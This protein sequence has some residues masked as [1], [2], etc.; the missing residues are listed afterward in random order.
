MIHTEVLLKPAELSQPNNEY[1]INE[2]V[3]DGTNYASFH[4]DGR[5]AE[6][7][8]GQLLFG[9]PWSECVEQTY[10]PDAITRYRLMAEALGVNLTVIDN[11]GIGQ[12]TKNSRK[13]NNAMP[14]PIA[15]DLA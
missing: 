10:R 12:A 14:A 2:T 1:E 9:L 7:D 5:T 4:G 3:V 8:N 15:A 6:R 11:P 13:S